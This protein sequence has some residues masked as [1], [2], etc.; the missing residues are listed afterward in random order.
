MF[1]RFRQRRA[2]RAIEKNKKLQQ[3]QQS[4]KQSGS[5]TTSR[6]ID[7]IF[8]SIDSTTT[9]PNIPSVRTAGSSFRDEESENQIVPSLSTTPTTTSPRSSISCTSFAKGIL[10]DAND[11]DSQKQDCVFVYAANNEALRQKAGTSVGQTSESIPTNKHRK[12]SSSCVSSNANS[13]KTTLRNVLD[14]I[15]NEIYVS[16]QMKEETL[17]VQIQL[18]FLKESSNEGQIQLAFLKESYN[19]V[20]KELQKKDITLQ[21]QQLELLMSR[22]VITYTNNALSETKTAF[23]ASVLSLV[24]MKLLLLSLQEQLKKQSDDL[25]TEKDTSIP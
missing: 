9:F 24:E 16:E 20:Q 19:E 4:S 1:R 21:Q 3:K 8:R 23:Q 17:T 25:T 14:E 6:P 7:T 18:A 13:T 11:D 2:L 10:V 22:K 15:Q 12:R 5:S